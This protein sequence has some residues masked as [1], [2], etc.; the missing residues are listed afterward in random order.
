VVC[1][2]LAAQGD[3]DGALERCQVALGICDTLA[4]AEPA[5]DDW[6]RELAYNH[7]LVAGL[8]ARKGEPAR[9]LSEYQEVRAIVRR[10]AEKHSNETDLSNYLATLDAQIARLEQESSQETSAAV[11]GS[12]AVPRMAADQIVILAPSY[13]LLDGLLVA[14]SG[15]SC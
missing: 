1:K 6:Q 4:K 2:L 11:I 13:C 3:I 14:L 9:A 5:N 12:L 15:A 7:D 8:V 10:L